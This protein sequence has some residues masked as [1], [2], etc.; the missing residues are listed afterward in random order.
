MNKLT[1]GSLFGGLTSLIVVIAIFISCSDDIVLEP[2]PSLLGKYEGKYEFITNYNQSDVDTDPYEIIVVF[3][4]LMY[5]F[6]D[7]EDS[8]S[9]KCICEP[10]GDYILADNVELIQK[11]ENCS[12]CT[13]DPNKLPQGLFA[14]RRPPDPISGKDSI[15]LTQITGDTCRQIRLVPSQ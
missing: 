1:R 6:Y 13:M 12:E 11:I 2:L 5:W 14:L 8:T 15:V 7:N 10:S 3:S 4:D 9:E